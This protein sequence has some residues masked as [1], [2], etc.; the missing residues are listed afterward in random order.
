MSFILDGLENNVIEIGKVLGPR[1]QRTDSVASR[2]GWCLVFRWSGWNQSSETLLVPR[3]S[4]NPWKCLVRVGLEILKMFS[5][6]FIASQIYFYGGQT[7]W[8]P[9]KFGLV[10][11][12]TW[13][14]KSLPSKVASWKKG[15]NRS[16]I[17]TKVTLITFIIFMN[18]IL[19]I[20]DN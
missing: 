18:F 5:P 11:F 6:V 12:D 19:K 1:D 9:Q 3:R 4:V 14:M 2:S 17:F 8:E 7:V 10:T 20:L 16:K 15:F 13:F